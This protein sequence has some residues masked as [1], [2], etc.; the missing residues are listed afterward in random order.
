MENYTHTV[1]EL[2]TLATG[3]NISASN[4]VDPGENGLPLDYTGANG[5]NLTTG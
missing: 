4:P 3:D 2:V 1:L 5:T